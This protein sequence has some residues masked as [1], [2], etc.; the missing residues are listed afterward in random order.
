MIARR[1]VAD[2]FQVGDTVYVTGTDK[3]GVVRF[4]GT[5][6][7]ASGVW[8][9]L[10][11]GDA[12]GRNDGSVQG[13]KYFDCKPMFGLFVRATI[14]SKLKP[15]RP[16]TGFPTPIKPT[17]QLG[18]TARPLS[19]T[20]PVKKSVLS[21]DSSEK[22]SNADSSLQSR[23]AQ[24]FRRPIEKSQSE[25]FIRPH[26]A[27]EFRDVSSIESKAPNPML[28]KIDSVLASSAPYKRGVRGYGDSVEPGIHLNSQTVQNLRR[29][30]E[31]SHS[32][33]T[34]PPHSGSEFRDV[35]HVESSHR[36]ND[37]NP[38]V[39]VDNSGGANRS[40][41]PVEPIIGMGEIY[42]ESD[43]VDRRNPVVAVRSR[44][45]SVRALDDQDL[46]TK[47]NDI[48]EQKL[49]SS[50]TLLGI[51][52]KHLEIEDRIRIMESDYVSLCKI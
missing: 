40:N 36:S 47:I 30:F 38:S 29:P 24:N 37:L 34:I 15:S 25:F 49:Q 1:T 5:V 52:Q 7:F 51:Y 3:A 13:Q 27:N 35:T 21:S 43:C 23:A 26:S 42:P 39:S 9:G 22:D 8:V 16:A 44:S 33:L 4:F 2:T 48:V 31:K 45:N 41:P 20:R 6:H 17:A 10:E 14:C 19:S 12:S 18:T 32:D 46:L 28:D 50:V 11:L